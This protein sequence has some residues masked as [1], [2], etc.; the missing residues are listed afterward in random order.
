MQI[1]KVLFAA[2]ASLAVAST[3]PVLAQDPHGHDAASPSAAPTACVRQE[4]RPTECTVAARVRCG[5]AWAP[6]T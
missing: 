3:A 4:W 6:I 2:A 5:R 1:F